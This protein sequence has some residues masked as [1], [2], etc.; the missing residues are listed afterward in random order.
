MALSGTAIGVVS[1]IGYTPDIFATPLYGYF[2]DTYEG[3]KGHQLVYLTLAL[4]SLVGIY[5]SLKFKN[6]QIMIEFLINNWLLLII[7]ILVLLILFKTLSIFK[8]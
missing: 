1:I 4:S 2:L 7:I 3:I 5:V 6:K 8:T